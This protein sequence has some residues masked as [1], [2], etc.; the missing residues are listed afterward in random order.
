MKSNVCYNLYKTP[1][2]TEYNNYKFYFSSQFNKNRFE[3]KLETIQDEV[4]KINYKFRCTVDTRL[5]VALRYYKDIEKR[6]FYVLGSNQLPVPK[7]YS[8]Q[9]VII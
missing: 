1:Y 9:V 7:D 5:L 2:F 8:G 3:T 4:L 6:G